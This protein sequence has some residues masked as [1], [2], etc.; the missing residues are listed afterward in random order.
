MVQN[1]V[2]CMGCVR[3]VVYRQDKN[4][5]THVL[6]AHTGKLDGV[7]IIVTL[8]QSMQSA[9]AWGSKAHLVF[10]LYCLSPFVMAYAAVLSVFV[11]EERR[12]S[13]SRGIRS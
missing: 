9:C 12:G 4:M 3:S 11:G 7:W 10:S 5:C 2:I 6:Q 1:D 13:L 8:V